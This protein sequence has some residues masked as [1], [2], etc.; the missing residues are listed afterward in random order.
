MELKLHKIL[1]QCLN[2]LGFFSIIE[3][4]IR[5]TKFICILLGKNMNK[6]CLYFFHLQKKL[7]MT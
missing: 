2:C 6:G 3:N 5:K 4:K 1:K 7:N